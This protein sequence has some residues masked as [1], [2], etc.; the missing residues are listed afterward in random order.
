MQT[1]LFAAHLR[2]LDNVKLGKGIRLYARRKVPINYHD[3]LNVIH[4]LFDMAE[5]RHELF[6]EP[7]VMVGGTAMAAHH[8]RK[9]S[10]DVDLY[11]RDFSDDVVYLVNR[12][13]N[14]NWVMSLKSM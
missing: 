13:S 8:I 14:C 10:Y 3:V 9:L 1:G 2:K 7:I 12:N 5:T 11:V 4:R 6:D